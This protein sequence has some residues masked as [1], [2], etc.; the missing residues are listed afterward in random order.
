VTMRKVGDRVRVVAD[1]EVDG[2]SPGDKG[3]VVRVISS[4]AVT[5][6]DYF[7]DVSMDKDAPKVTTF[8]TDKIGPD[9]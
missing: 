7:Y 2:Y 1:K 6:E 5:S 4:P 8:T 3:T 9:V